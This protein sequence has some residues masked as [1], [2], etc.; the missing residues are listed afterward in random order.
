[1]SGSWEVWAGLK[2]ICSKESTGGD[3]AAV[4]F[5]AVSGAGVA[6]AADATGATDTTGAT[7]ATGTTGATGAKVFGEATAAGAID[8]LVWMTIGVSTTTFG[9][10]LAAILDS[11]LARLAAMARRSSASAVAVNAVG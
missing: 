7:G 11:A 10:F 2:T 5:Q 1:M 4:G 3:I 8:G 6:G 9:G